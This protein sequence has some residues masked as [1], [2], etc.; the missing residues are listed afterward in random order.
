MKIAQFKRIGAGWDGYQT[1][2]GDEAECWDGY[3]RTSEYVEVTFPQRESEGVLVDHL[4]ALNLLE[5][6][7]NEEAEKKRVYI[8]EERAKLLALT[9]QPV[10]VLPG[11]NDLLS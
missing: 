9:H 4:A 7:I 5:K 1:V 2:L 3:V 10:P 6:Q 8:Q 11:D